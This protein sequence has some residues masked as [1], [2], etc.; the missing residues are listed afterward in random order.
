MDL[1]TAE[2]L[3]YYD[4]LAQRELLSGSMRNHKSCARPLISSDSRNVLKIDVLDR[5][6]KEMKLRLNSY[7]GLVPSS[8][9]GPTRGCFGAAK[10]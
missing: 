3:S 8:V 10:G 2:V 6:A 9:S 7:G 1:S 5:E 4:T